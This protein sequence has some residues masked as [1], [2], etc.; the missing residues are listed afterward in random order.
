MKKTIIL[1]IFLTAFKVSCAQW[2][3]IDSAAINAIWLVQPNNGWAFQEDFRHWDGTNW[4]T[5]IQDSAFGA[6]TCAFTAPND[7]WVF[8]R[9]DSLFRFNG[10][11]WTKQYSG[12]TDIRYCDFYDN[13]NGWALGDTPYKYQN[14]TWTQYPMN[15][16]AYIPW[17]TYQSISASGPN[18]AWVTGYTSDSSYIFKFSSNQWV[19]DT[20]FADITFQ[21]ICFTDQNHGWISGWETG[22]GYQNVIYKYNGNS[23]D[24]D[25]TL[26]YSDNNGVSLFMYNNNLGWASVGT[27]GDFYIYVYNGTSW[28]MQDTLHWPVKQ[29]SFTDPLNGWALGINTGHPNAGPPNMLFNTTS[30][31]AGFEKY[32]PVN[33]IE[34]NIFPNPATSIISIDCSESEVMNIL[35]YNLVGELVLQ[36]ELT[37]RTK[38]IDIRNLPIGMYIIKAIGIDWT[39]QK[40]IIKE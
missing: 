14:G 38:E 19:I 20:A 21:T 39:G 5:A 31:G 8:G 6:Q 29:F 12:M 18:T 4:T 35:I 2:N 17:C 23:W 10:S 33:S 40:K 32:P 37:N 36:R 28:S 15:L 3:A 26:G 25:T 7:G 24:L 22:G 9:Q 1:I 11:G 30:G 27:N 34:I 16:P 13:M